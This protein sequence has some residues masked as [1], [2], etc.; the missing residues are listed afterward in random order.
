MDVAVA[1]NAW[2]RQS[3]SFVATDDAG[4]PLVFIRAP[5]IREHGPGVEVLARFEGEPV[6]VREGNVYGATFHPE[7]TGDRSIHARVFRAATPARPNP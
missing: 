5:R 2:G 1:R 6:L 3:D 4:A 7:L